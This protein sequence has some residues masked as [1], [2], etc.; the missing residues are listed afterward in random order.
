[1]P[2]YTWPRRA[3]EESAPSDPE[4]RARQ[5]IALD[6]GVMWMPAI[7]S[8][9]RLCAASTKSP[10]HA[11]LFNR[12]THTRWR[13]LFYFFLAILA[14]RGK[15]RRHDGELGLRFCQID[16]ALGVFERLGGAPGFVGL[17]FV[18]IPAAD[19]GVGEH[20]DAIRLHFENAARHENEFFLTVGHL[21]AHRTGFDTRD[22]RRVAW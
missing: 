15:L 16:L 11:G 1:M 18:Q 8:P 2:A 10:E 14:Q 3:F 20:G 13:A 9:P 19:C 7:G 22:Q 12:A 6:V 21:N 5:L 17:F 4:T